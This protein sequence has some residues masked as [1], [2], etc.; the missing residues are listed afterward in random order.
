MTMW[1]IDLRNRGYDTTCPKCK[2]KLLYIVS[3][4]IQCS[5][6]LVV[7]TDVVSDPLAIF[8]TISNHDGD[9]D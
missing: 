9:L 1:S 5:A 3:D 7:F 4:R 2:R 6:C 8:P